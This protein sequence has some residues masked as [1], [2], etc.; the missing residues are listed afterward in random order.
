MGRMSKSTTQRFIEE[1]GLIAQADGAPRI[2]GQILGYLV[3]AG[4]PRELARIAE[5][6]GV[7]KASVSTNAR[8]LEAKGVLH[9][10]ARIGSRQDLWEADPVP[11]HNTLAV[12][13]DRF[14]RNADVITRIGADFPEPEAEI[15]QRVLDMAAFYRKS[16]HFLQEW[17]TMLDA[18]PAVAPPETSK[19]PTSDD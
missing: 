19:E 9:R 1:M 6:L 4:E 16:A 12:L 15:R 10:V 7:S 13:A 14:R 2:A 5:D 17:Q 18:D 3:A 11:H 8:L